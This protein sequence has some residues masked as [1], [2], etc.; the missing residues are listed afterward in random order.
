MTPLLMAS[1]R[2]MF[3]L[4]TSRMQAFTWNLMI[5]ASCLCLEIVSVRFLFPSGCGTSL[6]LALS[7]TLWTL[8]SNDIMT[9]LVSLLLGSVVT[10]SVDGNG[11]GW[12]NASLYILL[13]FSSVTTYLFVLEILT[14]MPVLW[15]FA[16]RVQSCYAKVFG[17]LPSLGAIEISSVGVDTKLGQLEDCPA[18]YP[19]NVLLRRIRNMDQDVSACAKLFN[20]AVRVFSVLRELLL[21][22]AILVPF[23]VDPYLRRFVDKTA[24]GTDNDYYVIFHGSGA[25]SGQYLIGRLLLT[26][27]GKAHRTYFPNYLSGPLH[28]SPAGGVDSLTTNALRQLEDEVSEILAERPALDLTL[29]GHSLGGDLVVEI[30]H[31]IYFPAKDSLQTRGQQIEHVGAQPYQALRDKRVAVRNVALLSTP[32]HGSRVL[33]L[34]LDSLPSFVSSCLGFNSM[35]HPDLVEGS[36]KCSELASYL[37][38]EI[39]FSHMPWNVCLLCGGTDWIVQPKSAFCVMTDGRDSPSIRARSPHGRMDQFQRAKAKR[40]FVHVGSTGHYS[41]VAVGQFWNLLYAFM[42]Q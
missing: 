2:G 18:E 28:I 11:N 23:A 22:P 1:D 14:V 5:L 13:S 12:L 42:T 34:L 33:S 9:P 40:D 4:A 26:I 16:C 38:E 21:V 30:L 29:M 20:L 17:H 7:T 36:R 39:L 32:F 10:T 35:P 19:G 15:P 25:N 8:C 27:R 37:H 31:R 24:H 3:R 6:F 41:I